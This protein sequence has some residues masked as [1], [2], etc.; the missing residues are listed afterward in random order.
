MD[1]GAARSARR[2]AG[3]ET[4]SWAFFVLAFVTTFLTFL[5]ADSEIARRGYSARFA[6]LLLIPLACIAAAVLTR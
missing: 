5:L 2:C 1:L 4:V 6:F 3:G